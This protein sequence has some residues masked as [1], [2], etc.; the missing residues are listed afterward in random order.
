L[1]FVC[2]IARQFDFLFDPEEKPQKKFPHAFILTPVYEEFKENDAETVGFL[3]GVTV[4]SNLLDRLLPEGK[5]GIIAVLDDTCGNTMSFEMSSG[6]AIFL[7]YEDVHETK[8]DEYERYES[9]LEMYE[10]QVEGLC[11]HNLHIYPSTKLRNNYDTNKPL[12]YAGVVAISFLLTAALLI[13][14]DCMVNLRQ[15]KT[16][17]GAARTQA[18]VTSLFPKQIGKK[19]VEEAY[20]TNAGQ[21]NTWKKGNKPGLQSIMGANGQVYRYANSSKTSRPLAELFPEATIMFGDLVG[22][23][24][25]SSMR[26]PSQVFMLLEGLY[27]AYDELALRRKVFKVETIGD[28]YVAV[29]GVP[30]VR[31]DHAKTMVRFARDCLDAM[32]LILNELT[33]DLGPDTTELGMRVGLHSGPVTGGVLR[34]DRARFQLFGDTVNTTAR[35]ESSGVKNRIHVSQE[36]ADRLIAAGKEHWLTPRDSRVDAK[37]KGLMQTYWVYTKGDTAKSTAVTSSSGDAE[38]LR[39]NSQDLGNVIS[40]VSKSSNRDVDWTVEI[41]MSFLKEVEARRQSIGANSDSMETIKAAERQ[42]QESNGVPFDEIKE[43]FHLPKYSAS[44]AMVDPNAI[45]L[46]SIVVSQLRDFVQCIAHTYHDNSFH[47]FEHASHVMLSV[48]KLLKRIFAQTGNEENTDDEAI[49]DYTFGITSDPLTQFSVVLSALVH[50]IDHSGV[51]NSRLSQEQDRLAQIYRGKSIAEQN[52]VDIAWGLL[53]DERFDALRMVIYST[54]QDLQRFRQMMVHTV[55]AT[56]IMDRELSQERKERWSAT[57]GL[58]GDSKNSWAKNAGVDN[59]V[60]R[61]AT[62]VIEH[63]MQASDVAHTM[64]HWHVYQKW[65]ARLFNETYRAYKEGRSERNPAEFWYKAEI[66]FFDYYI[67]PLAQKLKSCGVFGVSGDEYLTYARQNRAEWEG[68]GESMVEQLV[69]DA[70]R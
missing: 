69:L 10:E 34:G 51:P 22:F 52:S 6:K 5:N 56:D 63:L 1:K 24:A 57:F 48:V 66:G 4:F 2:I 68:K 13:V 50:D 18:I 16:M 37:G 45:Q 59:E 3:I 23:T 7:G 44:K 29:C 32:H 33:V 35:L 38:E 60:D 15:N 67:I 70:G 14:Y 65:N 43:F 30:A 58:D 42:I 25:W 27:S 12:L 54:V 49:H 64:Q 61:K 19:M 26:E 31:K 9:N 41:L 21:D 8:F 28:C 39:R 53:M 46:E 20:N 36:T 62:I 17:A 47:N 40:V 55:L 11:E